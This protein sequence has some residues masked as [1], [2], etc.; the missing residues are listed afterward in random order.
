MI[1]QWIHVVIV[2]QELHKFEND[3]MES[4]KCQSWLSLIIVLNWT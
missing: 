4:S 2:I 1:F 3:D